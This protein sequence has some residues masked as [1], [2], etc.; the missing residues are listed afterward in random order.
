MLRFKKFTDCDY[1]PLDPKV[2]LE[3][4]FYSGF[5]PSHRAE[6]VAEEERFYHS[7]TAPYSVDDKLDKQYHTF[8]SRD[9]A[10]L[11]VKSYIPKNMID[12]SPAYIF[13][14]GGGFV[15]CSVETHDFV[16]S[17]V[18]ANTKTAAFSIEYRLAPEYKFPKGLEDCY[19]AILWIIDNADRFGIDTGR[20]CLSG[21]SGGGNFTAALCVMARSFGKDLFK[22]QILIYPAT[23]MSGDIYKKSIEIYYPS[24]DNSHENQ[25]EMMSTTIKRYLTPDI[26]LKNPLV[27]PF[28]AEDVA[29]FPSA[30]FIQAECDALLD[31]GL[32]YAQKLA[33]AGVKVECEI[34]KGMPHAFILRTYEETFAALDRM[35]EF[36]KANT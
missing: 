18:A 32:I 6:I 4:D 17:Y 3:P 29:G 14:H 19:D 35:C 36:F 24:S 22:S 13:I 5:E 34:Y 23:D 28:W 31:D 7:I 26:D 11:K 10:E 1:G 12:N 25:R 16:P 8:Y 21:D 27:S 15:T 9:S 30:L 33:D 20:L 2:N